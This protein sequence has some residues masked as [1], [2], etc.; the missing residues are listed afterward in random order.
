MQHGIAIGISARKWSPRTRLPAH[1]ADENPAW[2]SYFRQ[3]G[4]SSATEYPF[5]II[6]INTLSINHDWNAFCMLAVR[7]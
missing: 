1:K 2:P 5:F 7:P 3:I 6:P 4:V